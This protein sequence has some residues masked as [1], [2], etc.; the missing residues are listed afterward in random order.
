MSFQFRTIP[1]SIGEVIWRYERFSDARS[2][3]I[4]SV[5][6]AAVVEEEE[7]SSARR[8]G[9]PMIEGKTW[10]GKSGEGDR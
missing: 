2:P 7:R 3:T 1:C 8:M 9:R 5:M 6:E 10:A 4:M